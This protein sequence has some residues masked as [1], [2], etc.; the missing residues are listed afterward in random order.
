MCLIILPLCKRP[1]TLCRI[2]LL[3]EKLVKDLHRLLIRYDAL[4]IE[5]IFSISEPN[6]VIDA[7][8]A[9][10]ASVTLSTDGVLLL[11][12]LDQVVLVG[13]LHDVRLKLL[14]G[15]ICGSV[16]GLLEALAR[17]SSLLGER[18]SYEDLL[19]DL[20]KRRSVAVAE[21][22]GIDKR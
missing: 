1:L 4:A 6:D 11:E 20:V 19:V 22:A 5:L 2:L 17:A 7:A 14:F 12:L 16:F 8:L 18:H 13:G 10:S 9:T 21:S 3:I 15:V